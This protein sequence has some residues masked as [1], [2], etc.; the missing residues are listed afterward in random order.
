MRITEELLTSLNEVDKSNKIKEMLDTPIIDNTLNAKDI[1]K[2][3]DLL[4]GNF[5]INRVM[6][7]ER[8]DDLYTMGYSMADFSAQSMNQLW[9]RGKRDALDNLI[10][11]L[12]HTIENLDELTD[13]RTKNILSKHLE[14]AKESLQNKEND[15]YQ[16]VTNH[17]YAFID[18][19]NKMESENKLTAQHANLFRP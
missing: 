9:E 6:R 15:Y 7:I 19:V 5:D 18:E 4:K 14:K 1:K 3:R 17:L 2:Y 11:S 16:E 12:Y 10:H 13:E 8:K